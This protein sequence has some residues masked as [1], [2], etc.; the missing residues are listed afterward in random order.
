MRIPIDN[1]AKPVPFA[2][3][4]WVGIAVRGDGTFA[5]RA[6]KPGIWRIDGE[7]RLINSV[8]PA[9][10]EPPLAFRGNDV[11]VPD[12]SADGAP[13]IL[14]QPVSG[15]PS[16]EIA[17]APGAV[18][19]GAFQSD[20]AVNPVTGEIIYTAEVSRDTNIDLLNLAKH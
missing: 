3:P 14:A 15:G 18:N 19:R 11:L 13:R 10:Y 2:P 6:D 17:R 12:Y 20:F 16:R 9:Y 7:I 1:G 5:T 8:Y 4:H